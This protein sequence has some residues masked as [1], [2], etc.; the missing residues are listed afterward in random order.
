MTHEFKSP[1]YWK[2]MRKLQAPSLKPQASEAPSSKRQA[3]SGKLQAPS[4]KLQA[5][6]FVN[7]DTFE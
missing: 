7:H 5:Q 2:E 1:K 3:Q 4:R 6:W